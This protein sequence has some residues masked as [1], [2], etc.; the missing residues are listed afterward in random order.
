LG[1]ANPYPDSISVQWDEY[2]PIGHIRLSLT[3][4][5]Q[6][7]FYPDSIQLRST[8]LWFKFLNAMYN[9]LLSFFIRVMLILVIIF[10]AIPARLI[11]RIMTKP[12]K[13]QGQ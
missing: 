6:I 11:D 13:M 12:R 8:D 5:L 3:L 7:H 9:N 1:Q 2:F 10:I 4:I